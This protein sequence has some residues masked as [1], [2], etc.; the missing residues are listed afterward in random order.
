MPNIDDEKFEIYLKRFRPVTPATL[1]IASAPASSHPGALTLVAAVAVLL[2]V[3]AL[4]LFLRPTGDV[5][6]RADAVPVAETVPSPP[7]TIGSANT[8]LAKAPS[9]KEAVDGMAFHQSN[10][11][12]PPGKESAM[13]VLGKERV[14]L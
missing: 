7:L 4:V 2:V 9:I 14:K 3:V 10:P 11:V 6:D 1:P 13:A 12:L 5:K 8:L